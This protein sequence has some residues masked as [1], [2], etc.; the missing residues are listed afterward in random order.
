VRTLWGALLLW[1]VPLPVCEAATAPTSLDQ[2]VSKVRDEVNP[3]ESMDFMRRIYSTDRWFT[4]PKFAQTAEYLA[5]AMRDAGLKNVEILNAPAD[6][7]TQ[8]GFWTMPMA[9]DIRRGTLEIVSSKL[10]LESRLLADYQSIPTSVGMWSGATPPEGVAAE[11]IEVKTFSPEAIRHMDLRGKF[12]LTG[13][14]VSG[15]K[16]MLI[17]TG[18]A[19]VISA[20]TENPDLKDGHQWLNAWGD[21]GWAFI[22]KSTPLVRFSISPR[23]F[24]FL[25][26]LLAGGPVKVKALVDS[27]YY[28]GQYPIVTGVIPGSGPEQEEVLTLGHSSEQGAQD[29]ATGVSAMLEAMASLHRLIASGRLPRPK[30]T[31]RI[32]TMGEMY[33][34]MPYVTS[35]LDRMR[36]TV[37][38]LC[39]DTPASPYEMSGT[40]Y[41][42]YMNPH[43]AKSYVDALILKIATT[44]FPRVQRPWHSHEYM[45]G[46]DTYL[47]DPMIGVPTSWAYSGTGVVTHHNSE[48][49]PDRVDARSLRDVSV[50]DATFLY[51][52][53]SAGDAE[54]RWLAEIALSRGYEQVLASAEPFFDRALHARE[55]GELS[56][57]L[58][59]SLEKIEYAV[60]RE[61]QAVVSASRLSESTKPKFDELAARLESFGKEQVSRLRQIADR[62]SAELGLAIA[63]RPLAAIPDVSG[64]RLVVQRKRI[65]T[66]PL[67]ELSPADREGYPSGAW[68]G[69]AI[70][71][72]YWCD[73][74]RNLAEVSRLT[75]L[76]LGEV[77]FDFIGYFRFLARH[78]YVDLIEP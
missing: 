59:D 4:F 29:N 31:I 23:Q 57:I 39:L 34:S 37:A 55:A 72:L 73:G 35:H 51:Y 6:G 15:S 28:E 75:R 16:W 27:R 41:T 47:S 46:T 8:A 69:V 18:A 70:R 76:E 26:K 50:V 44:Y 58:R 64:S 61:K 19:G 42:F 48:D 11:V 25:E 78:G 32:L 74:R 68:S 45:S 10:P 7:V 54:A 1:L 52:L 14:E 43:V 2:L 66:I 63:V 36:R 38:A 22:K 71:A 77:N 40:E 9:W 3:L 56:A 30:R 53:A 17:D 12:I 20:F 67:D 65:G 62:R 5:G 24:A 33:G 60:G 49:T 21:Y 13:E